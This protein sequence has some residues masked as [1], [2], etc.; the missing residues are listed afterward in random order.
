MYLDEAIK[1]LEEMKEKHGNVLVFVNGE[2]GEG[3]PLMAE[4][5]HF[6]FGEAKI[7]LGGDWDDSPYGLR[8]GDPILQ[9]GGY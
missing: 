8:E 5:A 7:T 1:H 6:S 9:I 4:T 2:H 3:E